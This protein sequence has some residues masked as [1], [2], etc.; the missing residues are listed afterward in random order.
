MTERFIILL[1]VGYDNYDYLGNPQL[2]PENNQQADLTFNINTGKV[3]SISMNGFYSWI[4][5]YITGIKIPP[6]EVMPQT[7][8]VLGVKRFENIENAYLYGFEFS[9]ISPQT[10]PFGG[11]LTAAY[12][13]GRNPEAIKY[14]VEDG[15]V[16]GSETVTND[17][18]PEIPPFETNLRV[19]YY[20]F[21]NKFKPEIH[22]RY[23]AAQNRISEAYDEQETPGFFTAG[24]NM[25]YTVN[26]NLS[27]AGG[28]SNI[29]DNAYYEHLNRRII[30]S[31][32]PL[33]EP[34][35]IFWL[36]VMVKF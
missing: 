28:I 21:E 23:V 22:L 4:T 36:N 34:G 32:V 3:G 9:W 7:K 33:Y 27:F 14:I 25:S 30:G 35:R 11:S 16:L 2:K 20:L 15:Q 8:G 6:S 13:A 10:K 18:L 5:D 31:D 17:P 12:T 24:L 19:H 29:F 1:P 26:Q